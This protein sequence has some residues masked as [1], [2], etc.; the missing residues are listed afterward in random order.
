MKRKMFVI[1]LLVVVCLGVLD[2]KGVSQPVPPSSPDSASS[3]TAPVPSPMPPPPPVLEAGA[4]PNIA[5][6]KPQQQELTFDQL[7]GILKGVRARQKDLQKQEA[8]LLA[9]L[10]DKV[11]EKRK[12]LRKAEEVFQQLQGKP[13]ESKTQIQPSPPRATFATTP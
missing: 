1:G 9:T 12:D 8:D 3:L 13:S 10:A 2:V 5:I 4:K 6:V 11:E 7:V